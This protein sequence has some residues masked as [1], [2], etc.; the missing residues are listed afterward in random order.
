MYEPVL[1]TAICRMQ[2][3]ET[4]GIGQRIEND[5]PIAGMLAQPVENEVRADEARAAGDEHS[6]HGQALQ[7][8]FVPACASAP[9]RSQ[10]PPAIA[11]P[12]SRT[13]MIFQIAA[14]RSVPRPDQRR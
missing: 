3:R 10:A 7:G 1:R 13:S 4:P 9:G 5:D 12:T 2:V 6:R 8:R 11:C 14:L